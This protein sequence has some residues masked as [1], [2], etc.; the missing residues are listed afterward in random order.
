MVS[1]ATSNDG[2]DALLTRKDIEQ[3]WGVSIETVKR[4]EKD[5]TLAPVYLPGGRL[6]RY[7]LADVIKAEGVIR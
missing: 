4:R 1:H 2:S 7:R 5:G 6:V 3:R